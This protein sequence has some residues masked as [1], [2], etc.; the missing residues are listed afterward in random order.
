[1]AAPVRAGSILGRVVPRGLLLAVYAAVVLVPLALTVGVAKPGAQGPLVVVADALGFAALSLIALQVVAS[2]RWASTTRHFGLRRVLALHRQAGATTLVLA[3]A[4]VALLLV[5]DP[6]R[7][8]LFD[9]PVAP[10][11]ARAGVLAVLALTALAGTSVWRARFGLR[12]ERWRA[13]HLALTAVVI[14]A[15]FVHVVWVHAYTSLPAERDAILALVL[16]AGAAMFWARVARPYA[17]AL[18]PYRVVAVRPERGR[19][20][21]LELAPD[22][23]DGLHF[24]AGQFARL[25]PAEAPYSLDDHPFTL[26]SDAGEP[27]RPSFT[28]KA[29]GDFTA[30]LAHLRPGTEVLVDGPHG[31]AVDD[32]DRRRGRLLIAAGIGIT[33]AMSVLRTAARRGSTRRYL[34]LY[35]SRAWADV[36]FREE[37]SLLAQRLPN[38]R[39]V[40]VLS[41]AESGWPGE[42][43]R[44]DAELVRRYAPRDVAR[45]GALICGPPAMVAETSVALALLGVPARAIQAEGFD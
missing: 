12:Y 5:D 17:S 36:T 42:R 11:R 22:G 29:L 33:P 24:G 45:W 20:V 21:T 3:V 35:G 43:G 18:R 30:S 7:L 38:L 28:V 25:R 34:L 8:R 37:L 19:A 6:S 9:L 27:G 31:E 14:A 26:S 41:R 40:H 1:V 4:H 10:G 2:G 16:A 32:G 13:A 23:H 44:V 15:S 39:V